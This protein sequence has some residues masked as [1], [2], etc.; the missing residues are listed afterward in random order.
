MYLV[1][2]GGKVALEAYTTAAVG[3]EQ[4]II[5]TCRIPCLFWDYENWTKLQTNQAM[6]FCKQ[7]VAT[8]CN[9]HPLPLRFSVLPEIP[10]S[11]S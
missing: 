6:G 1:L 3:A 4:I 10:A 5:S 7:N 8:C 11:V 2:P 9:S